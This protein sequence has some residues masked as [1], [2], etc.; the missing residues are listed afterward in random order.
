MTPR[1]GRLRILL[2]MAPGVGKTFTMLEEGHRRLA[3]GE[4]V[5]AG[6][7]ETYGRPATD[8]V[9]AGLER[10]PRRRFK[11]RGITVE[12]MDADL[13][14]RRAPAVVLID[15]L[16]HTNAPG[17][18]LEKRWQ[19]VEAIRDAGIDVITTCNVQHVAS[20][21]DR[22]ET[23]IGAPV[24]ERVPD[25]IVR[26]A[27]EI[28]LVDLSPDRL[29]RRMAR[30]E[31]YPADRT[32]VALDRFF[33]EP[34]LIALRDLCLHFLTAQVDADLVGRMSAVEGAGVAATVAKVMV[35]VDD[36]DAAASRRLVERATLLAARLRAPLLVMIV[37]PITSGGPG[38]FDAGIDE[39]AV[40]AANRGMDV[41]RVV[42]DDPA[43]TIA[44][45]AGNRSV[46]HLVISQPRRGRLAR[47]AEESLPDRILALAPDLEI[48]LVGP[49]RQTP[50]DRPA[51][52]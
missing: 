38:P 8:A 37:A 35:V 28:Q 19:D 26:G 51:T 52:F 40:D 44:Q 48:S 20:V 14:R 15:E 41:V 29:R 2:G 16:A 24:R 31:V 49:G 27:D 30:G 33:T 45:A 9:L 43:G 4:D 46:T 10:V 7:V 21:A 50:E 6:F 17:S 3:R 25:R 42:T 32:A 34:N 36:G 18:P 11:Y 12:E 22:V 23:M 1:R 47:L 5:V 13:I 39:I